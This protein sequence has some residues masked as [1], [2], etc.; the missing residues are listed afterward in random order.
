MYTLS[1]PWD[2]ASRVLVES[3]V[4]LGFPNGPIDPTGVAVKGDGTRLIVSSFNYDRLD[5]IELAS[6]WFLTSAAA[7]D[8]SHSVASELAS[9]DKIYGLFMRED[10]EQLYTATTNNDTGGNSRVSK[11]TF[12]TPAVT[13]E[14]DESELFEGRTAAPMTSFDVGRF[15]GD[16]LRGADA[17]IQEGTRTWT[18]AEINDP[19]FGV[20]YF[21]RGQQ[22]TLELGAVRARIYYR[23]DFSQDTLPAKRPKGLAGVAESPGGVKVAVG[24]DGKILRRAANGSTWDTI[25]SGTTVSLNAV[26]WVGDRFVAVGVGGIAL[27]GTADGS[28]WTRIETGASTSLWAIRR[29]PGT[30]RAVAVGNDDYSF[31]RDRLGEWTL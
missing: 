4:N 13:F 2:L 1:T 21:A 5:K 10:G 27:E 3:G 25:A 22:G 14:Y 7:I 26:E 6:P 28:T 23:A 19:A 12:G 20:G 30:L 17:D 11:Y 18:A 8:T 9:G 15:G 16:G 29:V 24:V 31:Q